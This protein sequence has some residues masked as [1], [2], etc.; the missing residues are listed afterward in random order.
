M[1][2]TA[3]RDYYEVLGVSREASA[4]EIKSA[5]RKQAL[6]YH[7]DKNPGDQSAEESFKEASEAYGV[8][9]D[10]EKRARYDRFG[11]AGVSGAGPQVNSEIFADFQ[12]LFGGSI[13]DMFGEMFGRPGGGGRR[14]ASRG[15][16]IQYQVALGFAEPRE[17]AEKRI[18]V[19]RNEPCDDCRGTGARGG[20]K[21]I[22][23]GR[24]HG[25]GQETVSRGF[26]ML[27]RTCSACRGEGQIISNPCPDCRGRGLRPRDREITVRLPAGI[28]DGNQL[29]ISGEGEHGAGGGPPGDLYVQVRVRAA[30]GYERRDADV[31]SEISLSFPEAALGTE[32]RVTTIWGDEAL[33]IPPGTQPGRVLRMRGKGFPRLRSRARGD[34][35]VRVRVRVPTDLSPGAKKALE[36]FDTELRRQTKPGSDPGADR[37]AAGEDGKPGFFNR[38]FS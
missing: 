30:E 31:L 9:G 15:R 28:A 35:L 10:P 19:S 33:R 36:S 34:H 32:A 13:A 24:C 7:P 26:M 25:T 38:I 37:N 1:P 23:C 5:Y 4:D 8:L 17:T 16:D 2:Q 11:H 3:K 27:S 21:P 29:R 18:Q 12:D 22:A 14:G 6:R 20:A